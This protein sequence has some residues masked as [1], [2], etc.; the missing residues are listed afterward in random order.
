MI[1][2]IPEGYVMINKIFIMFI[3]A[4]SAI[5]I[6]SCDN[7]SQY[8]ETFPKP[9]DTSLKITF[10]EL[11][12]VNCI[13]CQQMQPVMDSIRAKYGRQVLVKFIDAIKNRKEADPYKIRV[14]PTQVFLDSNNIEFFRH[15]GFFPENS[16]HALLQS[17]GLKIIR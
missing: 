2:K 5:I 11:G 4:F 16:I 8:V 7:S 12:S 3:I 6:S 13:P 14:M 9:A 1:F 17:K 15:E 10:I